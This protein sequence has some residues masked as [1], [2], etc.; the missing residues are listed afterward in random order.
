M[1]FGFINGTASYWQCRKIYN[2][3]LLRFNK[4]AIINMKNKKE[5]YVKTL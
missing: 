3:I 4:N 5:G 1:A 2:L